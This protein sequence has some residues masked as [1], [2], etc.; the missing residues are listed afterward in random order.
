MLSAALAGLALGA[1]LIVSIGPQNSFVLQ[2]G[3]VGRHVVTV[4]AICLLSDVVLIVAGTAGAAGLVGDDASVLTIARLAGAAFVLG[5]A[6]VTL[7]RAWAG[8]SPGV[9]SDRPRQRGAAPAHRRAAAGTALA[10]TWLNPWV[11]LDTLVLLGSVADTYLGGRW[12]FAC[13]AMV[14]S[15]LWFTGLG[16]A[17]SA[18]RPWFRR[19]RAGQLMDAFVGIVMLGT[20][21]RLLAGV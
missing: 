8:R 5:Y 15:A 13:G 12:W 1:S 2:A 9:P 6:A 17:A 3:A 18:I 10:F 14:A 19:P 11:Y 16:A 20:A 4:V 7:R 21:A